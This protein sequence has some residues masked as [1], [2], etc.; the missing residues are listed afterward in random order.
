MA[1]SKPHIVNKIGIVPASN[2]GGNRGIRPTHITDHHIVGDAA[3]ALA[4]AAKPSRQMSFT[5]TIGS[6]GTIYQAL[7]LETIPYTDGNF[8]SNRRSVTIEHAGGHPSVPYTEAMYA[9]SI[10]LHAWLRQE[11]SIPEQNILRHQQVSNA[12]TA[13]PGGLNT[14]RIKRESTAM[15]S[16]ET[17]MADKVSVDTSKILQHGVIARN[18]LSGRAYALDGSTGT[19]WVGADLTNELIG[20]IFNSPE[21][22]QWRDSQDP[23]SIQDIN[24]RLNSIPTLAAQVE[25]LTTQVNTLTGVVGIKD[26]VIEAQAKEIEVLKAQVGDEN[27][28]V[29]QAI[30]V[31]WKTITDAIGGK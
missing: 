6:D 14:D 17:D 15:L 5:F 16:G 28:T 27:L 31:L 8:T 3:S 18:G 13:C 1:V 22:K 29:K 2:H 25:T 4:E 9:S 21:G 30:R 23:A 12:P 24:K 19:P 26:G 20:S 10:H 11:Y 7:P